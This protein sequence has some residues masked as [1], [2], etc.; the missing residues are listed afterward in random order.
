MSAPAD[1]RG[2]FL[3]RHA[4]PMYVLLWLGIWLVIVTAP[5]AWLVALAHWPMA[6]VMIAGSLVAGSTPMGGGTVSFPALVLGFH[7]SPV[8]ARDFG[9]A[10]QATGMTSAFLFILMRGIPIERRL[11]TWSWIGSVGGLIFGTFLLA[12]R[13]PA[14][15]V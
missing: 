2:A 7:R 15:W 6:L 1:D 8:M 9:M 12:G 11:L 13:V 4:W 14:A 5:G 3:R 10:I